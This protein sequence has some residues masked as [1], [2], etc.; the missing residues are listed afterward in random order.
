MKTSSQSKVLNSQS[1]NERTPCSC[2]HEVKHMYWKRDQIKRLY[3][4]SG[5]KYTRRNMSHHDASCRSVLYF[6]EP[7]HC[8]IT[9][10]HALPKRITSSLLCIHLAQLSV[11]PSSVFKSAFG[12]FGSA[13]AVQMSAPRSYNQAIL[14]SRNE[15]TSR[16]WLL[17]RVFPRPLLLGLPD[18]RLLVVPLLLLALGLV[19]RGQ[20]QLVVCAVEDADAEGGPAEDLSVMESAAVSRGSRGL[21]DAYIDSDRGRH[22]ARGPM[23]GIGDLRLRWRDATGG[24]MGEVWWDGVGGGVVECKISGGHDGRAR[25]VLRVLARLL[26]D[27]ALDLVHFQCLCLWSEICL[28][29]A[30]RH[31]VHGI[32]YMSQS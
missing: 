17:S 10:P 12:S 9:S 21:W 25:V 19:Q 32:D 27:D 20:R 18:Q 23:A 22:C 6:V 3:C 28:L 29:L 24:L 31:T 26:G 14:L 2:I 5:T 15:R 1:L 11:M 30:V 4:T 16:L 7:P 13:L 8:R